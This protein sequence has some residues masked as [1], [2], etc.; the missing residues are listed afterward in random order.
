MTDGSLPRRYTLKIQEQMYELSL[1]T[2]IFIG[3]SGSLFFSFTILGDL[4][5]ITWAL[6]SIFANAVADK[7]PLGDTQDGGYKLYITMF[8][9]I[10]VPLACTSIQAQ[11]CGSKCYFMTARFAMALS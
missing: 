4:Y 9:V 3:K 10:T 2:E 8:M 1:L 7:L 5:V 11:L 6:C